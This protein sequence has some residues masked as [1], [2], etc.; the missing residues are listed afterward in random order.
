[1]SLTSS[2]FKYGVFWQISRLCSL[3]INLILTN[4]QLF[5]HIHKCFQ[6]FFEVVSF[7]RK[8]LCGLYVLG[9]EGVLE[10]VGVLF[11]VEVVPAVEMRAVFGG[12]VGSIQTT[13]V[14]FLVSHAPFPRYVL[15]VFVRHHK[16]IDVLWRL[17]R[18]LLAR[19][20]RLT[21]TL[22]ICLLT[23]TKLHFDLSLDWARWRDDI[24]LLVFHL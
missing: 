7:S 21:V 6:L 9:L 1:M 11:H 24:L 10:K 20:G 3:H 4:F 8:S 19:V 13:I 18:I 2:D 22:S 15:A 5:G 17:E 16:F 12:Y 14:Y 23:V